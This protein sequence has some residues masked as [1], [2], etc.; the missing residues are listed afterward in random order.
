MSF[1]LGAPLFL[2]HMY[3]TNQ[4]AINR[5]HIFC[6]WPFRLLF[7]SLSRCFD[8]VE[9]DSQKHKTYVQAKPMNSTVSISV[10]RPKLW[11]GT[12]LLAT[13]A[14]TKA[15]AFGRNSDPSCFSTLCFCCGFGLFVVFGER[16]E[17]KQLKNNCFWHYSKLANIVFVLFLWSDA[18]VLLCVH[19][20]WLYG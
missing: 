18:F 19:W 10:L 11:W 13:Y 17:W 3:S 1:G 4:I 12:Q 14:T 6:S 15:W 8:L 20:F 2:T 16:R 5:K 9:E 7:Q